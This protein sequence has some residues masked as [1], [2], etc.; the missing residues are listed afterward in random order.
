M[1]ASEGTNLTVA[2]KQQMMTAVRRNRKDDKRHFEKTNRHIIGKAFFFK[3]IY[4]F[5][6]GVSVLINLHL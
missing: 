1:Y 6:R 5:K 2:L 3:K 4:F